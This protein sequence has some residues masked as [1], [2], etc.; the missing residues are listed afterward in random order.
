MSDSKRLFV[1]IRVS[2]A[3]AN[4][5]ARCAEAVA[6]RAR[7][8][9][10]EIAWVSPTNYHLTLKF[11]GWSRSEVVA[12]VRDHIEAALIG[13]DPFSFRTAR[14]GGFPSL[15]AASVLWAGTEPGAISPLADLAGRIDR[16]TTALGFSAEHRAFHPHVTLG[17]LAK[18]GALRDIVLPLS[19]QMFSTTDVDAVSLFES[20]NKSGSYFYE[21]V[22]KI[23]FKTAE[24]DQK[25]QRE[26]VDPGEETD[27]GWSEAASREQ[28]Q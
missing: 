1:G 3:T 11:L 27:D 25:R 8:A 7:D 2:V 16:A 10:L 9:N 23:R 26:A 20:I 4:A 6:R 21:E 28:T 24:I 5:L 13:T 18:V 17:R 19:E 12:A 15:E 22:A 14:L